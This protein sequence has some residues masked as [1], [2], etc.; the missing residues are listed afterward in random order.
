MDSRFDARQASAE[1]L[2]YLRKESLDIFNRLHSIQEDIHFVHLVHN[3]YPNL[4]IMPNLR[5]GAW[6]VDPSIA[7]NVPAYFKSTDGHFGNWTFN[8]RRPN[9]HLLPIIIAH[10]GAILVDST[11]AGKRIPD[12]LSKTVP[13]WCAVINRA[14]ALLYPEREDWDDEL[15]CPPTSVSEQERVQIKARI[16]GWAVALAGSGDDHELW[17]MGLTP[18][19]FWENK[20]KLLGCAR[21]ELPHVVNA[22]VAAAKLPRAGGAWK[23]QPSPISAVRGRL[24]I[25]A[26]PDMPAILPKT[27][28]HMESSIS[29]VVVSTNPP[30]TED[31]DAGTTQTQDHILRFRMAEG[32]KDQLHFLR[33]V[34]PESMQF[35]R[36]KL[37]MGNAICVCCDSGKDASVGVALAALQLYFDDEG[38]LRSSLDGTTQGMIYL[39]L[40]Y[41]YASQPEIVV[42]ASKE[43]IKKRLQWIISSRPEA[44]P[45]RVT[46]KRVNEFLLS[47]PSF[48]QR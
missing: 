20:E 35:I 4:P 1:A 10:G 27:Q 39:E 9:L 22:I 48:R 14:V 38:N 33:S 21:D 17:G 15:Y 37:A 41:F 23:N 11:R 43:S 28:P 30:P 44:N 3:A 19:L 31:G 26:V 5:C 36:T 46:L 45:S 12:A 7:K 34:L 8:L 16:E 32:K 42:H 18:Q 24:L 13:V 47:S 29:Y 40:C 25:A 2:S 6:Y